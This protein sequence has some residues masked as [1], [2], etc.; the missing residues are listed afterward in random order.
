MDSPILSAIEA[1]DD[2]QKPSI[3]EFISRLSKKA[4]RE[5][6]RRM[7]KNGLTPL[8]I[9]CLKHRP[10]WVRLLLKLGADPVVR[11]ETVVRTERVGE[12]I[13]ESKFEEL[14]GDTPLHLAV[15][16][17]SYECARLLIDH[18]VDLTMVN[19]ANQSPLDSF[20]VSWSILQNKKKDQKKVNYLRESLA[21]DISKSGLPGPDDII[22]WTSR[23][24]PHWLPEGWSYVHH[25]RIDGIVESLYRSPNARETFRTQRQVSRYI[26]TATVEDFGDDE[27]L[28]TSER[29]KA[30]LKTWGDCITIPGKLKVRMKILLY[31]DLVIAAGEI[32]KVRTTKDGEEFRVRFEK[33]I[34][35]DLPERWK[36]KGLWWIR[37]RF[38]VRLAPKI[39]PYKKTSHNKRQKVK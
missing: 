18:G 10:D 26:Q 9:A 24:R 16:S 28:V 2:P 25:K 31:D 8:H 22:A 35:D 3:R 4:M 19:D 30:L 23:N 36:S 17:G 33:D 7:N 21:I 6:V 29:Q 32:T 39:L 1:G 5:V 27:E 20:R 15:A 14:G 38:Q 37:E 34:R 12:K 13:M 11:T